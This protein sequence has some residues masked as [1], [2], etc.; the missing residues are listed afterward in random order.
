MKKY[1]ALDELA[2]R[3]PS[4]WEEV[5]SVATHHLD[6]ADL[7][8]LEELVVLKAPKGYEPIEDLPTGFTESQRFVMQ[9]SDGECFY[10]NTEGYGYCRYALRVI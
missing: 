4:F 9:T 5:E 2:T 10:I 7:A 1:Q 6:P 8:L 3:K